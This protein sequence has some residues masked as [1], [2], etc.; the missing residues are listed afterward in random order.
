MLFRFIR[1]WEDLDWAFN[2]G[3]VIN[4]SPDQVAIVKRRIIKYDN[5]CD[6]VPYGKFNIPFSFLVL[7]REVNHESYR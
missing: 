5:T 4:L 3:D 6:L 7:H 2:V 1:P